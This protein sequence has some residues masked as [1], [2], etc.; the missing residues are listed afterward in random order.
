M[1]WWSRLW[2]RSVA[3]VHVERSSSVR[4]TLPGWSEGPP[5]KDGR[6]WRDS[7]GDILSPSFLDKE[8]DCPCESGET[9]AEKSRRVVKV[10]AHTMACE[11]GPSVGFIH[12]RMHVQPSGFGN[13]Q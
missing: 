6:I 9:T 7:N 13:C 1:R 5:G 11:I 4:L 10:E 12:K 2:R 3:G 8:Q